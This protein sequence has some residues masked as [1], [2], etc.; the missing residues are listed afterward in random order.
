MNAP[1]RNWS[2]QGLQHRH[3]L[4]TTQY[5]SF[6]MKELQALDQDL[7]RWT[8]S[9]E[10][11]ADKKAW[12]TA[13][14]VLLGAVLEREAHTKEVYQYRATL[15]QKFQKASPEWWPSVHKQLMTR[16]QPALKAA[17]WSETLVVWYL[18]AKTDPDPTDS[19]KWNGVLKHLFAKKLYSD[20]E[21]LHFELPEDAWAMW[22]SQ[23]QTL[24][25]KVS[26]APELSAWDRWQSQI[27]DPSVS[28][29]IKVQTW[30]MLNA[31]GLTQMLV[32]AWPAHGT[33]P[34]ASEWLKEWASAVDGCYQG[35]PSTKNIFLDAFFNKLYLSEEHHERYTPLWR[36]LLTLQPEWAHHICRKLPTSDEPWD[37]WPWWDIMPEEHYPALAVT[38]FQAF[39]KTR[40]KPRPSGRGWIAR[41]RRFLSF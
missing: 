13:G 7:D 25:Q 32:S 8:L 31:Q 39:T 10:T 24:S 2:L 34:V 27:K 11:K 35:A 40:E 4:M 12:Y 41:H 6:G 16:A 29:A 20:F 1:I 5:A 28:E 15:L 19:K 3:A 22:Q 23:I 26:D 36:E 30:H 37:T 9:L 17:G 18:L 33:T 38:H 21:P 14:A